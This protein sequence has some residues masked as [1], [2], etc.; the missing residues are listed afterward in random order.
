M[1]VVMNK[2]FL[3][4]T[5]T[6]RQLAYLA[7]TIGITY[8]IWNGFFKDLSV[9]DIILFIV[10]LRIS[11]VVYS[12]LHGIKSAKYAS[13]A[14]F[15][16]ALAS[17][18]MRVQKKLDMLLN[19]IEPC[20]KTPKELPATNKNYGFYFYRFIKFWQAY[21]AYPGVAYCALLDRPL[22]DAKNDQYSI[23][24]YK[25]LPKTDNS[26]IKKKHIYLSQVDGKVA[27]SMIA[28]F[29]TPVSDV[30][31]DINAPAKL[32]KP[33]LD[34]LK[35]DVYRS[36]LDNGHIELSRIIILTRTDGLRY[37][38]PLAS[39]RTNSIS[40]SDLI[41]LNTTG[42]LSYRKIKIKKGEIL[43]GYVYDREHFGLLEPD[44]SIIKII[45]IEK[46]DFDSKEFTVEIQPIWGEYSWGMEGEKMGD[47]IIRTI[48]YSD[49]Y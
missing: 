22:D 7:V 3:Y 29:E 42:P 46:N 5:S 10:F 31:T 6:I 2:Y 48:H 24:E 41:N 9:K 26:N 15:D 21:T 25:F 1:G 39:Y 33:S 43:K 18:L 13:G 19:H 36:A 49:D 23:N 16:D 30:I 38:D 27:Y 17:E 35:W 4:V 44:E 28:A 11:F 14:T 37:F 40:S 32:T 45:S 8:Y 47:P 20:L 34:K 12:Y